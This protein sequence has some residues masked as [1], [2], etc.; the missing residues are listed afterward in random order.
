VWGIRRKN[1]AMG[2]FLFEEPMMTGDNF[3]AMM[4]NTALCRILVEEF[5]S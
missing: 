3:L 5:S 4:E 1:K 2:P